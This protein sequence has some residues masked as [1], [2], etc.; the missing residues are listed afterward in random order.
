MK[1]ILRLLLGS[2]LLLVAFAFTGCEE[3]VTYDEEFVISVM[4]IT[5][6][7]EQEC[8]EERLLKENF[9]IDLWKKNKRTIAY[10]EY[11]NSLLNN[12][13]FYK[14]YDSRTE[15]W[16]HYTKYMSELEDV[17]F[18]TRMGLNDSMG[19]DEFELLYGTNENREEIFK[20]F[21]EQYSEFSELEKKRYRC[22]NEGEEGEQFRYK[23]AEKDYIS[24]CQEID[25]KNYSKAKIY[26]ET[27]NRMCPTF[28][29]QETLEYPLSVARAMAEKGEKSEICA[30]YDTIP[31]RKC[32]SGDDFYN[33][34]EAFSGK[35]YDKASFFYK[36]YQK[37]ENEGVTTGDKY[38]KSKEYASY[39][40]NMEEGYKQYG[41]KWSLYQID[42]RMKK[43]KMSKNDIWSSYQDQ[44]QEI[45]LYHDGRIETYSKSY[46]NYTWEYEDNELI[47]Y[48]FNKDKKRYEKHGGINSQGYLC[49]NSTIIDANMRPVMCSF[50]FTK[51]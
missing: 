13:E 18:K 32:F 6:Y 48:T 42:N 23:I 17:Y 37:Y 51:D 5:G 33:Y 14:K 11:K 2:L 29:N 50:F 9:K 26:F 49:I 46:G 27:L 19:S 21:N 4:N 44:M 24:G 34:A 8:T 41:G 30:I 1:K 28:L 10:K 15:L 40:E 35:K 43:K 38:E 39:Y 22:W 16:T 7:E 3:K 36:A 45:S 25:N 20:A 47:I 31:G 12:P